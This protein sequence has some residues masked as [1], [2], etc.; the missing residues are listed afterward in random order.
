MEVRKIV[1]KS[2]KE[3]LIS[4]SFGTL[5]LST[6]EQK[7]V[8]NPYHLSPSLSPQM[9]PELIKNKDYTS[10]LLVSL[11]LNIN[12]RKLLAKV[13]IEHVKAIVCEL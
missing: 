13:P 2:A 4:T 9:I 11:K 8:F 5:I 10:A 6:V 1:V 7:A 3:L 12:A